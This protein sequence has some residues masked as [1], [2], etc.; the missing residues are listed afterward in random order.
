VAVPEQA[1]GGAAVLHGAAVQYTPRWSQQ[2]PRPRAAAQR[3]HREIRHRH[4]P[5]P[6]AVQACFSYKQSAGDGFFDPDTSS[7][8]SYEGMLLRQATQPEAQWITANC[9][10][11][12]R[13]ADPVVPL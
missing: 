4:S 3:A 10:P 12:R 6:P 5:P 9:R 8:Y 1:E 11:T 7:L 13:L 2:A